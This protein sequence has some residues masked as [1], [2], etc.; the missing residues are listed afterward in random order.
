MKKLLFLICA[1]ICVVSSTNAQKNVSG[2]IIDND[3]L[4]LIGANVIIKGTTI[5]TIT[6]IDGN[7]KLNV[8]DDNSVLVIS[9]TGFDTK[10]IN[11]SDANDTFVLSAG[12]LLD[13]IVFT[14]YGTQ[15]KR[16]ITGSVTS[17]EAEDIENIQSGHVMQGLTGKVAGVQ[18]IPQSGQPGDAPSIRFRGIGSINASNNPLY[19]VDGVP[20]NGNI[21]SIAQQ[22]IESLTF[23]KDASANALYGSR[24][25]NGV[26]IVTTKKGKGNG[27]KVTLDTKIGV[28][29]R[30][31]ADYD[32]IDDP[33]EYYE[34][35]FNRHRIG[36]INGG[37]APTDAANQ[38]AAELISGGEYS[39]GYNNYN[40]ADDMV[41]DPTTGQ[42]RQGA[43]L[44]Y[45]DK[46]ADELFS[47]ST[48]SETHLSIS[49]RA[50]NVGTFFSVGYLNDAGYALNSGFDRYTGRGSIDYNV[51]D[52]IDVGGS[53]NYAR[54]EQDAPVQNVGSTTYSN[55]FS[56]ARNVAPIY[57]VY[58]RDESGA[59][60]LDANGERVYDFGLATDNIPGVRP[61]GAFNNPVATSLLDIDKNT[62]NNLSSRVYTKIKFLKDFKFTYNFSVDLVNSDIIAFA[63]PIGGDASGVNGRLTSTN[64]NLTSY[65]NQQLLEYSKS[66]GDHNF[67][68]LVGHES[69]QRDFSS[70]SAQKTEALIT[71]LP[72]LNNAANIQYANGFENYYRVEGYLSRLN[73][74]FKDK[75]FL[76]A[77]FRRDGSSVFSADN[78]WGSFY[79]VGAAWDLKAENFL[80]DIS[81]VSGLRIRASYGQQGNDALLYEGTSNRN[82]YS[83]VDQF[84]V[85]NAGGGVP[86]VTF[87]SLGN[88]D[89]VWETSKNMNIGF[90][91]GLKN[92]RVRIS[93]EY[94]V[95]KV[96]DLLFYDP[97]ALSEG[98]GSFA[99]NIGDMS[100]NG[101]EITL[102]ADILR[103][104]GFNWSVGFNT[105][106][107]NN[108]ITS[109]PQ[110]FI[111]DGSFRLEEGRNRYEYYMREYAGIETETGEA[112]WFVDEVDDLGELTGNVITTTVYN[113][114][115][116]YF[117]GKSAVPDFYGGVSTAME[118]KGI[119]LNVNFAYQIGG[120]G[121]DGVYQ[122]LLGSAPDVGSNYHRD[123]KDSWTPENTSASIPRIDLFDV[124]NGNTSDFYLID[125][126][127]FSLQDITLSYNLPNSIYNR[128]GLGGAKLYISASNVALWSK[129]QGYDPRL[130]IVGTASNEYSLVKSI[131]IGA[132]VTF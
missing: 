71:D 11:A 60:I 50:D 125:A 118:Y 17:V 86:G 70:L 105:T 79:G 23:L 31:I 18:I 121:Y 29:S 39:L 64:S 75:Y 99:D 45:Q 27:L 13:E 88:E 51:N 127:Y 132:N 68:I 62:R 42:V 95:R 36:L 22:D 25:A 97:L 126:S 93:A 57:T 128:A 12:N 61:Y 56:W 96:E 38:A 80:S 46:W 107:F 104:N 98:R 122:S 26:I 103:G 94:F 59:N 8:P 44:L 37:V 49:N 117:I 24:G 82:Y 114:A 28:N 85:V 129:R 131:S 9:Y 67:G 77:S 124:D 100:N 87:V 66:M 130:S 115:T 92:D 58:G 119:G 10:E 110:E 109:L 34:T 1:F 55:L 73:Y 52:H 116:E 20:F 33:G 6:D 47:N 74:D 63:T 76:N 111:D 41:I 43:N 35:W 101:Y 48:R 84:N 30:A 78:R 83:Y 16:E 3:G 72:V 89:L 4:P 2:T 91:I 7:Y 112:M 106:H 113:E 40:V 81:L 65:A 90:D 5:G 54:T 19:V 14:A 123:V 120:Y 53:I 108:E 69:N 21:N 15:R 102:D 32:V